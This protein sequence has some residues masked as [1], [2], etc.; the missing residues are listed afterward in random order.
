MPYSSLQGQEIIRHAYRSDREKLGVATDGNTIAITPAIDTSA[1]TAGDQVAQ[2]PSTISDAVLNNGGTA[3]LR[4]VTIVDDDSNNAEFDLLFFRESPSLDSSENDALDVTDESMSSSY[5]GHVKVTAGDY[6]TLANNSAASRNG[7]GLLCE[8]ASDSTDLFVVYL[9][10]D[11]V[12]YTS[13][14]ALT[15]RYHFSQD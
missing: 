8:A 2:G 7:L 3:V 15:F 4:G 13:S 6:V 5:L 11:D 10:Q 1:F 9:I 14:T 12:T